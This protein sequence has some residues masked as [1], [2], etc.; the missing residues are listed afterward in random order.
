[1]NLYADIKLKETVI[2]DRS[3]QTKYV[4]AILTYS[5]PNYISLYTLA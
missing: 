2:T 3:W 5:D 4:D 1:M